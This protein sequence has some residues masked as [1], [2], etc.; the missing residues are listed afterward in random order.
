MKTKTKNYEKNRQKDNIS[1]LSYLGVYVWG[2]KD[3]HGYDPSRKAGIPE[4]SI[5][6]AYVE[7]NRYDT[8]RSGA[9]QPAYN[10]RLASYCRGCGGW[11]NRAGQNDERLNSYPVC[12]M[13][14][15][16][17]FSYT[18][19]NE[20]ASRQLRKSGHYPVDCR[21]YN[22]VLWPFSCPHLR[23]SWT[24]ATHSP[25]RHTIYK[26]MFPYVPSHYSPER[27]HDAGEGLITIY[28]SSKRP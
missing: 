25:H 17:I 20:V 8:R 23:F 12:L 1:T 3:D 15:V 2:W 7:S 11:H 18:T 9:I 6:K 13:G 14:Y 19:I 22:A 28:F 16:L 24:F 10:F 21:I 5:P 27:K 4:L 26:V